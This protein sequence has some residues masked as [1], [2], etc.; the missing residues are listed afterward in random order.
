MY[1]KAMKAAAKEMDSVMVSL[2]EEHKEMRASGLAAGDR[3]FMDVML[4]FIES[5]QFKE[6]HDKDTVIKATLLF[7]VLASTIGPLHVTLLAMRL[8]AMVNSK[9]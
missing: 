1:V 8:E 4:S 5:D 7:V 9:S 3:D 2:L 6:L